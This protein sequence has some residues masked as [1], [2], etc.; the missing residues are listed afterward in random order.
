MLP[1]SLE[2]F[3]SCFWEGLGWLGSDA[4]P[5]LPPALSSSSLSPPIPRSSPGQPRSPRWDT[6]GEIPTL[7]KI[8]VSLRIQPNDGPVYFK[9][10]GQRFDQNR[11]IKF[12]TGAKYT[13]EVVLKPGVVHATP[14]YFRTMGIGGVNI[15][16]EEKSR[17]PQVVCYTGTYDTEGVPHTKSGQRQPLQ[18]NIQWEANMQGLGLLLPLDKGATQIEE[19]E[20]IVVRSPTPS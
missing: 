3:I 1:P 2:K 14:V 4:A 18:V 11:T 15:L 12:L 17:D 5:P 13:V 9:V 10:D 8:N 7:V 16:L 20:A 6:M 19:E